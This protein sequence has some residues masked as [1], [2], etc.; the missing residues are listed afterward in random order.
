MVL[1]EK[2]ALAYDIPP[3]NRGPFSF[4]IDT[5]GMAYNYNLVMPSL[6]VTSEW[7][8]KKQFLSTPLK[9][10]VPP[11]LSDLK[12]KWAYVKKEVRK[13]YVK[14]LRDMIEPYLR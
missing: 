5:D 8:D 6:N 13:W 4:F 11:Q 3:Q 14:N 1:D 7:I 9:Y 2:I 12:I 10:K